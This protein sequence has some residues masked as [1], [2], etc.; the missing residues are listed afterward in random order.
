MTLSGVGE[1]SAF[2]FSPN[3]VVSDTRTHIFILQH[4]MYLVVDTYFYFDS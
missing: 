4:Y 3:K 2:P 1:I